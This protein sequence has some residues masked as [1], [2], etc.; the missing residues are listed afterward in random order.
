MKETK[1]VESDQVFPGATDASGRMETRRTR[2]RR[3]PDGSLDTAGV[4]PEGSGSRLSL[5]VDDQR[6]LS[7][8]R[9]DL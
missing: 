2:V 3:I 7:S 5:D 6:T 1:R 8:G 4:A 9:S